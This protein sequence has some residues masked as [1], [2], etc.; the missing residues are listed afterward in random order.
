MWKTVDGLPTGI[1][2][3]L[4]MLAYLALVAFL[5]RF[6]SV[7]ASQAIAIPIVSLF[8]FLVLSKRR[9]LLK[10]LFYGITVG[11]IVFAVLRIF[12]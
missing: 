12:S 8:S 2:F 10:H 11:L 3:S 4:V 7:A 1:R 5:N 6:I 9:D